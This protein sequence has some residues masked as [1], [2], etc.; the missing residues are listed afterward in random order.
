M[1]LISEMTNFT[2]VMIISLVVFF[3]QE[4]VWRSLVR[5]TLKEVVWKMVRNVL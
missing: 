2:R 3:F 4:S 5:M 1:I